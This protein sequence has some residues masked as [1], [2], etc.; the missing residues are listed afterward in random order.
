MALKGHGA[1]V[2][3]ND[4]MPEGRAD[5][6]D[7]H[8]NEHIPERVAIPGFLR[9]RRYNAIDK[10]TAPEFLTLYETENENVL[11]SAA[12][13]ARL[14]DPTPWTKRTTS[15]FRNTSRCLTTVVAAK[16]AG[17]GRYIA[18]LRIAHSDGGLD[19]CRRLSD[20][21]HGL[22]DT[23]VQGAVTG[24]GACLSDI[25]ASSAKTAESKGRTDILQPPIG[26][27]LIEGVT[28][29][30]VRAAMGKACDILSPLGDAEW[31]L[32]SLEYSLD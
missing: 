7:W 28:E 10:K 32:Y 11:S 25:Q 3:W 2:I 1:V 4:I 9:G 24:M 26:V 16:G 14:N 12:Y 8:V 29:E 23:I 20:C 18:T 27:L 6:Y 17:I 31:G 21:A 5:F 19:L 15:H 13:L 22:G 30:A